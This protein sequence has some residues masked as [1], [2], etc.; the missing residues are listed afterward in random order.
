MRGDRGRPGP[1][2]SQTRGTKTKGGVGAVVGEGPGLAARGGQS[3]GTGEEP[4]C[5]DAGGTRSP[6]LP[7]SV[8]PVGAGRPG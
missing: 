6:D 3:Q 5:G 4:P 7:G 1:S 8:E 2:R